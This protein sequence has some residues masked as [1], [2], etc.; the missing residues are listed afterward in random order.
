[1]DDVTLLVIF[2]PFFFFYINTND[3]SVDGAA[4]SRQASS[5]HSRCAGCWRSSSEDHLSKFK[6]NLQEKKPFNNV[7]IP[8]T[9]LPESHLYGDED[10]D[11]PLQPQTVFLT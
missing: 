3:I 9:H 11:H 7:Y 6:Q 4:F 8:C 1:M 10:H 5:S 2:W